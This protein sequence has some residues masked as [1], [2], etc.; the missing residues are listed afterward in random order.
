MAAKKK[1]SGAAKLEKDITAY[2]SG[3][4]RLVTVKENKPTGKKD[5]YGHE[6]YE[7]ASVT[8]RLGKVV[9]VEEWLIPPSIPDLLHQLK[10]TQE[11]WDEMKKIEG[12]RETCE[13]AERRVERYLRRELLTRP[14]KE[15]KGVMLTLQKDFGFGEL[16][17][18]GEAE[19]G[20]LEELLGGGG[21]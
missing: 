9:K 1:E 17:G 16:S 4:S 8:N 3:I 20:S 14:N 15:V 11:Q 10:L 19:E 2:F 21:T 13:A 5:S 6:I 12:F 18:G 7:L